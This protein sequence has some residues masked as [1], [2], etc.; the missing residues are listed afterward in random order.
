MWDFNLHPH[1]R[2]NESTLKELNCIVILVIKHGLCQDIQRLRKYP[3][4]EKLYS[5]QP[6]DGVIT[7]EWWTIAWA[8]RYK[9]SPALIVTDPG[10]LEL[11]ALLRK[12][13]FFFLSIILSVFFFFFLIQVEIPHNKLLVNTQLVAR[14]AFV[15]L[16]LNG[17]SISSENR[18]EMAYIQSLCLLRLWAAAGGSREEEA[19]NIRTLW[20]RVFE[21]EKKNKLYFIFKT[22]V[23]KEWNT[24]RSVSFTWI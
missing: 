1:P 15:L 4:N 16:C 11:N 21:K 20:H 7:A 17:A 24:Q 23:E 12:S 3:W 5:R 10:A 9:S 6:T 13:G 19:K 22:C 18:K 14:W 2:W 8:V